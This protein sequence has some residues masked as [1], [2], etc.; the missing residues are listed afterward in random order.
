MI[1]QYQ[2]QYQKSMANGKSQLQKSITKI[3]YNIKSQLH[4]KN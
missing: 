4:D 1:F 3:N 2:L